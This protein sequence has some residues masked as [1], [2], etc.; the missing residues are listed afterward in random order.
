MK[1][2]VPWQST[3]LCGNG[4]TTA[5]VTQHAYT[6]AQS[7]MI[8]R[9]GYAL[10]VPLRRAHAL[11]RE[12]ERLWRV[13]QAHAG[14]SVAQ[15]HVAYA[16]ESCV[17]FGLFPFST[18]G[19]KFAFPIAAPLKPAHLFAGW[20]HNHRPQLN[21]AE[22][23]RARTGQWRRG[24]QQQFASVAKRGTSQQRRFYGPT[25]SMQ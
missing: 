10:A 1:D 25:Q 4:S 18:V 22:L 9:H 24:G 8:A 15:A 11:G 20:A 21:Q 6:H 16:N 19:S 12:L 23:C 5:R 2:F 3:Y 14:D 7:H 13:W 17:A